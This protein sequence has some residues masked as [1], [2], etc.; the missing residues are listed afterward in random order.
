MLYNSLPMAWH[1]TDEASSSQACLLQHA[2]LD[3]R[4]RDDT[5]T[6]FLE[7]V[8]RQTSHASI[9]ST[10]AFKGQQ[11]CTSAS[12]SELII[13]I[14]V[15]RRAFVAL[16]L[17]MLCLFTCL[18]QHMQ[19]ALLLE[20]LYISRISY[21]PTAGLA[22]AE[23]LITTDACVKALEEEDSSC[24][25]LKLLVN[26]DLPAKRVCTACTRSP[27]LSS[28]DNV[29]EFDNQLVCTMHACVVV[30]SLYFYLHRQAVE[31]LAGNLSQANT[32]GVRSGCR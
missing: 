2:D 26:Y 25:S 20:H 24:L 10:Q 1:N 11:Q 15:E 29:L 9:D 12:A 4:Q 28:C 13:S 27:L 19:N 5:V 14:I 16:V 18:R 6:R 32:N 3:Q 17:K 21:L 8:S 30:A 7:R 23:V 31:Y 22:S